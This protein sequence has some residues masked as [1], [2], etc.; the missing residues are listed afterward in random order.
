[1]NLHSNIRFDHQDNI[2]VFPVYRGVYFKKNKNRYSTSTDNSN[3]YYKKVQQ[4][5]QYFR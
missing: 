1:M 4:E 3:L 5:E 2:P